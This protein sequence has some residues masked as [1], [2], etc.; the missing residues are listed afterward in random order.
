MRDWLLKDLRL[1]IF[2]LA[3]AFLVWEAIHLQV[4]HSEAGLNRPAVFG[5]LTLGTNR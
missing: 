3:L 4:Q 2:C 1:K 5:G